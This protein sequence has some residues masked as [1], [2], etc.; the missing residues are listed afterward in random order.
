[1]VAGDRGLGCSRRSRAV[2]SPSPLPRT[3][4]GRDR[5]RRLALLAAWTALSY[6]WAPLG[7]RASSDIQR[8]VLYLGFF[9]AGAALLRG[10]AAR[11]GSSRRARSARSP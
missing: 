7:E 2:V 9:L 11:R 10:P 5:A 1:M 3:A 8:L 4:S 6:E